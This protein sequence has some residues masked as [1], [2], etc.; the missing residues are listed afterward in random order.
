MEKKA[1]SETYTLPKLLETAR[2][3]DYAVCVMWADDELKPSAGKRNPKGGKTHVTRDNVIFEAGLFTGA[4]KR[5]WNQSEDLKLVYYWVNRSQDAFLKTF[6][7][8]DG[9][10]NNRYTLKGE[11]KDLKH[12]D[13]VNSIRDEAKRL[14]REISGHWEESTAKGL[15][16]HQESSFLTCFRRDWITSPPRSKNLEY[17]PKPWLLDR[18]DV[19]D[20]LVQ[21]APASAKGAIFIE[22]DTKWVWDLFPLLLSWRLKNIPITVV[23]SKKGDKREAIRRNLLKELGCKLVEKDVVERMIVINP[24]SE[25]TLAFKYGNQEHRFANIY[26]REI[27]GGELIEIDSILKKNKIKIES[28]TFRP[29]VVISSADLIKEKLKHGVHQYKGE[30]VS[31]RMDDVQIPGAFS[32]GVSAR[33][34]RFRQVPF[35]TKALCAE[36]I[37]LFELA[38]VVLRSGEHSLITPPVVEIHNGKRVFIEGNT[39]ALHSFCDGKNSIRALVV[40]GVTNPPPSRPIPIDEVFL[41][42]LSLPAAWRQLDWDYGAFRRIEEAVHNY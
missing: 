12:E 1:G 40:E 24:S 34:Y 9:F 36:G 21:E 18:D 35:M 28:S 31:M 13:I 16:K 15:V 29:Q 30:G 7:D 8:I 17:H 37:P 5:I 22:K 42:R 25:D 3:C 6:S 19:Y 2:R 26:R 10:A 38:A 4:L 23:T 27:N 14:A 41:C 20:S 11:L 32:I 33:T 39:R